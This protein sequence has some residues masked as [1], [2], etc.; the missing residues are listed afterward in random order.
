MPGGGIFRAHHAIPMLVHT[1]LFWL[2]PELTDEQRANFRRHLEGLK[3]IETVRQIWVGTPAKTGPRP[4]IDGTFTFCLTTTFDDV[5]GQNVYQVHPIH[6]KFLE[7]FR[8]GYWTKVLI[9]DA[10]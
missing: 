10:D 9:Y 1:V 2:R 6:L 7:T 3:A 5:A 4:T 8:N